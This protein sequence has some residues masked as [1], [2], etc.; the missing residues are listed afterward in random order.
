MAAIE[1]E[2]VGD[3]IGRLCLNRPQ[4]LNA[5]TWE[6]MDQF[7]AQIESLHQGDDLRALIIHGAGRAFCSGGD[8]YELHHYPSH[9]DGSRLATVMGQALDRLESLPFPTLAAI[10]GPAFGGG[11]ELALACDLRVIAEGGAFGMMHVRLA[12][13]P[14]WGGGQRLL[15]HV[16]YARALEWLATGRVLTAEE[17]VEHRIA[18]Q[19]TAKGEAFDRALQIAQRMASHDQEAV[20]AVKRLLRAGLELPPEQARQAERTE[21]PDL[22]ASQPHLDASEQFVS[23]ANHRAPEPSRE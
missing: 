15:N 8:L 18:L 7:A 1:F 12:I 2:R 5:L 4:A 9:A 19:R 17:A 21:F 3:G 11:A 10:E 13:S 22:W 14:A 6:A 16:G 20:R 23:R